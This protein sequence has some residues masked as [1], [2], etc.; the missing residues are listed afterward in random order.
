MNVGSRVRTSFAK[1]G[2]LLRLVAWELRAQRE[3][4]RVLLL[5]VEQ[6]EVALFAV[7]PV[8]RV[9]VVGTRHVADRRCMGIT[10]AK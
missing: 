9:R 2:Y 6:R 3:Q 1:I 10:P 5:Y 4:G 7:L 8:R